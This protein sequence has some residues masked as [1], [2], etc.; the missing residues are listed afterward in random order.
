MFVSF[1]IRDRP[2]VL[3]VGGGGFFQ[4]FKL[5][6][7]VKVKAFIFCNHKLLSGLHPC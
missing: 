3:L 1:L 7:L 6:F 4:Q 2:S 5:D